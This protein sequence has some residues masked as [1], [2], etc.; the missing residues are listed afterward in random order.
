MTCLTS[1]ATTKSWPTSTASQLWSLTQAQISSTTATGQRES[2]MRKYARRPRLPGGGGERD[3]YP[4]ACWHCWWMCRPWTSAAGGSSPRARG[5]CSSRWRRWCRRRRRRPWGTRGACCCRGGCGG[6]SPSAPAPPPRSSPTHRTAPA[7]AARAPSPLQL[8]FTRSLQCGPSTTFPSERHPTLRGHER[9]RSAP[10]N[11]H[12][13][14]RGT[15]PDRP[16]PPSNRRTAAGNPTGSSPARD[17]ARSSLPA[18][19]G[20]E[21]RRARGA[22]RAIPPHRERLSHTVATSLTSSSSSPTE[23]KP[24]VDGRESAPPRRSNRAEPEPM[25]FPRAAKGAAAEAA[26][27]DCAV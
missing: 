10:D 3:A 13:R 14:R 23:T 15:P 19:I 20:A 12:D 6:T 1:S 25:P 22:G 9:T 26:A 8:R 7:P 21:S 17:A 18:E 4:R 27:V 16:R 11:L 24:P 5:G 2:T